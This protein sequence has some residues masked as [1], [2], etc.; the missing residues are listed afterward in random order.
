M[1]PETKAKLVEAMKAKY[2]SLEGLKCPLCAV[3]ARQLDDRVV[4]VAFDDGTGQLNLPMLKCAM[5]QCS[6]CGF[7][8]LHNPTA[9]GVQL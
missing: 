8:M 6:N 1:A 4:G 9:L 3:I 2:I 7:I 5:V